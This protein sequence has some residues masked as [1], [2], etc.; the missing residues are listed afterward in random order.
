M[1]LKCNKLDQRLWSY[2][3]LSW[4]GHKKE[5]REGGEAQ[6]TEWYKNTQIRSSCRVF[7]IRAAL[8]HPG[9]HLSLMFILKLNVEQAKA[10]QE[11]TQ[12][13]ILVSPT[14]KTTK[15]NYSFF[16][17]P[18]S[19]ISH[20]TCKTGECSRRPRENCCTDPIWEKL[21]SVR[22]LDWKAQGC[23]THPSQ[24]ELLSALHPKLAQPVVSAKL[25]LHFHHVCPEPESPGI[26]VLSWRWENCSLNL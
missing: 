18:W 25:G 12:A 9:S 22:E 26:W 23:Q 8:S 3:I 16:G 14:A 15:W 1:P 10:G 7:G 13:N 20:R 2:Q 5:W 17:I 11:E 24:L 6:T 4:R 19:W 21:G